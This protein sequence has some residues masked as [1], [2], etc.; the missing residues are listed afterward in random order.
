MDQTFAGAVPILAIFVAWLLGEYGKRRA[1]LS[2]RKE[3]RYEGL[4]H[5]LTGFYVDAADRR[6]RESFLDEWRMAWL[7]CP[8]RVVRAGNRFLATVQE[9]SA[10]NEESRRVALSDFVSAIRTDLHRMSRLSGSDFVIHS[11]RDLPDDRDA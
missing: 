8:D 3:K 11:V 5:A 2:Q 7:Y 6:K 4:L 1:S 10:T 9:G